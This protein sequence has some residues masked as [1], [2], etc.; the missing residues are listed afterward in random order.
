MRPGAIEQRENWGRNSNVWIAS[1][2]PGAHDEGNAGMLL[3]SRYFTVRQLDAL[4][5]LGAALSHGTKLPAG[6]LW[7]MQNG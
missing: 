7:R 6:D 5:E 4:A 2:V 3:L 1:G